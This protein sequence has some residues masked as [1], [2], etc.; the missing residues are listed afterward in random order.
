[1]FLHPRTICAGIAGLLFAAF[2]PALHAQPA[3]L[4]ELTVTA[5]AESAA[6]PTSFHTVITPDARAHITS[7]AELVAQAPGTTVRALGSPG[8]FAGMT[9]RGSSAEQVTVYLDGAKLNTGGLGAVD[10]STIPLAAV[11]S[12][13]ILRGPHSPLGDPAIGGV[14]LITTKRGT[15]GKQLEAQVGGGS[16]LTTRAHTGFT[17][18][19]T[20]RTVV[21]NHTHHG[22][23]GNYSFVPAGTTVAGTT[24]GGGGTATREHNRTL[25]E[26]LLLKYDAQT[27]NDTTIS[28]LNDFLFADRQL[29]GLEF[30]ST[31]LAP[32]NPLEATQRLY[33]NGTQASVSAAEV[34]GSAFDLHFGVHNT[35]EWSGFRDPSP[36]LGPAIDR[37]TINDAIN[38][39]VHSTRMAATRAGTHHLEAR[40][41]ARHDLFR[42]TTR[43]GA[44]R[45]TD[46]HA[47]TTHTWHLQDRWAFADEQFQVM[48]TVQVAH[49]G[50]FGLVPNYRLGMV[51]TPQRIVTIKGNIGTAHRI[52]TFT[53]LYH[54]DFGFLRGNPAL[55]RERAWEWDSGVKITLPRGHAETAYFQR[56][57]GNSILFVPI[58][59]TTIAPVNTFAAR[60]DGVET[61]A[62][63]TPLD[64]LRL[65]ANYTWLRAH[66]AGSDRQLPGRPQHTA[67]GRAEIF[68]DLNARWNGSM[69]ALARWNSATPINIDNTVAIGAQSS[70]DL[71]VTAH[72]RTRAHRTYF[73]TIECQDLTNAQ[74]YDAKGFPLPRRA[75]Y[76]SIGGR[77]GGKG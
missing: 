71:G 40:Y 14:V 73:G 38:P 44:A 75:V 67:H 20:Q 65:D 50:D 11:E 28:L 41:A 17:D 16:F 53:E 64:W 21:A 76:V 23:R 56:F 72:W 48:P 61:T 34:W 9:I 51:A 13:E 55:E 52:P 32:A 36:A 57:I 4:P 59:A 2:P 68:G 22:S 31:Q 33:R 43:N 47:R 54:P 49:A 1:M 37:T 5:P 24:L 42:D 39:F 25:A 30:E 74:H 63:I 15:P 58:S 19:T 46:A 45:T 29:P 35:L 6:A 18:R 62:G 66:F 12:I 77:F 60:A 27:G 69:Y 7:V 70:L 10:L 26:S 3:Q 8:Q